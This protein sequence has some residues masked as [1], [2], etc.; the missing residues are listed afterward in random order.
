MNA[1][2]GMTE[3]TLDSDLNP[4][5]RD[6]LE[7]VRSATDSLLSVINDLLDFSKMEAG[8]LE[9]DPVD[10]DPRGLIGD[11]MALLGRR[12]HAKGIELAYRV[13]PDVPDQLIGDPARLRQIIVNLV[14]NAI[15][16]TERGEVVVD[17]DL[18]LEAEADEV[19]L[20]FRVSDTGIGIAA[21]RREAV[22]APFTQADGSTT[23]RYG[24]TGLG[25]AISS[26][27]VQPD[28]RPAL[29]GE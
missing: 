4:D 28:G 27:L 24:G 14:G 21:D 8:K 29:G 12:A 15:K 10:F 11:I 3:L 25:L 22:F 20:H 18:H 16:F 5:Q 26:Q 6:N 13:D 23:R 9:L 1:I 17:V 2:L 19:G 7:I